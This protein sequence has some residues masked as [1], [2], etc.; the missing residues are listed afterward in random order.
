MTHTWT[1]KGK[2][3]KERSSRRREWDGGGRLGREKR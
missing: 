3:K 1:S 2:K